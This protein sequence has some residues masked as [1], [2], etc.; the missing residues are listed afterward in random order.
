MTQMNK[1][2]HEI[3]DPTNK[4]GYK[5][6]STVTQ[7]NMDKD[8]EEEFWDMQN[9]PETHADRNGNG[10]D[11][12]KGDNPKIKKS[13][14]G[15]TGNVPADAKKTFAS[16]L[17]KRSKNAAVSEETLDEKAPPGGEKMVKAIK[18]Q[19]SKDGLTNKEKAIAY[20]TAWKHHNM[21]EDSQSITSDNPA[22]GEVNPVVS[23]NP[24]SPADTSN[25]VKS[26]LEKIALQAADLYD[27]MDDDAPVNTDVTSKINEIKS[28]L[29]QISDSTKNNSQQ[30]SLEMNKE[31]IIEA[32]IDFLVDEGYLEEETEEVNELNRSGV[33]SRYINKT[34]DN[35]SRKAGN[36]LA[37]KKKWGDAKYGFEEPKVKGMERNEE[38]EQIT[39]GSG[40]KEKQ[41]R[42]YVDYFSPESRAKAK[43]AFD[44]QKAKF[45]QDKKAKAA[46]KIGKKKVTEGI[47]LAHNKLEKSGDSYLEEEQLDEASVK[48]ATG[49][50]VGTH[51]AGEGF[52]PNALGK[53]LGH[54][55]HPTDVPKGTTITK[56]GRPV[57]AKSFG[58]S[59]RRDQTA[60]EAG[61]HSEKP[62][63]TDEIAK[64]DDSHEG[65]HVTF[66]NGKRHH[67]SRGVARRVLYHIGKPEK[68]AD[69]EKVRKHISSS[70]ENMLSYIK[71]PKLPEEKPAATPDDK[72]KSRTANILSKAKTAGSTSGAARPFASKAAKL[73]AMRKKDN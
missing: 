30:E 38:V 67:V 19:Y 73:M 25:N 44:A 11:V 6:K 61:A 57:G 5:A 66:A 28:V 52:K 72:I 51:K 8:A 63:F 27:Q 47:G 29:E 36:A 40:P 42:P 53:K 3:E 43:A 71:N 18:K 34:R 35:P 23:N 46:E 50:V 64:A 37:L 15:H 24:S 32:M 10:D 12:F 31:E 41:K 22:Q 21:K 49:T 7:D 60:D 33:L 17:L 16:V 62:S 58:A 56:R 54:K 20:A 70:H 65:G 1:N 48:D 4:M 2:L 68:P 13:D 39:E 26:I 14:K 59:K 55:A 9:P 69:K 45:D